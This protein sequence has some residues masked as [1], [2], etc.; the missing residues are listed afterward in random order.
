MLHYIEI[1]S[2]VELKDRGN[3][4]QNLPGLVSCC[5]PCKNCSSV[6]GT[7]IRKE[8]LICICDVLCNIISGP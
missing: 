7:A 6:A 1:Q 2:V 3:G 5:K 8:L 4:T